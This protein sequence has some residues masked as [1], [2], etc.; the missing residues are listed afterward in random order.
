MVL[1][2][3][4]GEAVAVGAVEEVGAGVLEGCAVTDGAGVVDG[5]TVVDGR[6]EGE[7][8]DAAVGTAVGFV[9]G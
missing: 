8:D 7:Q 2:S 3:T 5:A 9:E 1:G 6:I 4:D